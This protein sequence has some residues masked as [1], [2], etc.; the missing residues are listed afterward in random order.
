MEHRPDFER[1]AAAVAP[2]RAGETKELALH[3]MR[4]AMTAVDA[5]PISGSLLSPVFGALH[6][7]HA[8]VAAIEIPIPKKETNR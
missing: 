1:L 4:V 7:A 3:H 2:D 6:R 5:L 8:A